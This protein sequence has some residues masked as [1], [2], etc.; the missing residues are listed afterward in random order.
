MVVYYQPN[1]QN[2]SM[3]A[4]TYLT[5]IASGTTTTAGQ[6]TS[7]IDTSQINYADLDASGEFNAIAVTFDPH[8]QFSVQ[9]MILTPGQTNSVD[10]QV[11]SDSTAQSSADGLT[12]HASGPLPAANPVVVDS[13]Y[14]YIR[15]LAWHVG[16]GMTS[17]FT[18]DFDASHSHETRA[19]VGA[20]AAGGSW[21]VG[22]FH[23]ELKARSTSR[24]PH[25]P[26][27]TT[28]ECG[29]TTIS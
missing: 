13:K 18:Y 21:S 10:A 2:D 3:G 5:V 6:F 7:A 20:Q 23:S 15:V 28:M 4:S 8:G 27:Q 1:D 17:T 9:N 11:V 22:G 16:D 29:R 24:S 25:V 19:T 12:P 14:R 26:E